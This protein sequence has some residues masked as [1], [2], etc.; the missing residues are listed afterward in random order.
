MVS[1]VW[2]F[3]YEYDKLICS[4]L[5]HHDVVIA[6]TLVLEISDLPADR[7]VSY[8]DMQSSFLDP[9]PFI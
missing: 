7:Y 1:K 2:K 6:D 9:L 3:G 8:E 4:K 5:G